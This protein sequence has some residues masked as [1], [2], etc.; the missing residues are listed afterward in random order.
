MNLIKHFSR[1]ALVILLAFN[2]KVGAM[3]REGLIKR[4]SRTPQAA[5]QEAAP[6]LVAPGG[7]QFLGLCDPLVALGDEDALR[8]RRDAFIAKHLPR[9]TIFGLRP[10]VMLV[11]KVSDLELW[12]ET[13]GFPTSCE[14]TMKAPDIRAGRTEGVVFNASPLFASGTTVFFTFTFRVGEGE[15]RRA[16]VGVTLAQEHIFGQYAAKVALQIAGETNAVR[17]LG[18]CYEGKT[19]SALEPYFS[20]VRRHATSQYAVAEWGDFGMVAKVD[21][22]LRRGVF[23]NFTVVHVVFADRAALAAFYPAA[24]EVEPAQDSTPPSR[25]VSEGSSLNDGE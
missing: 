23:A 10:I 22:S 13:V 15:L 3:Q 17:E 6:L 4:H 19:G 9:E 14:C 7:R 20:F 18:F 11:S 1:A 5:A 12:G 24:V 16:M 8:T 25:T 21:Q 2:Y